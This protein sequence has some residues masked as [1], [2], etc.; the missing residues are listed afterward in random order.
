MV[1]DLSY[2]V[3]YLLQDGSAVRLSAL[4]G[5]L[6]PSDGQH[7]EL[8]HDLVTFIQQFQPVSQSLTHLS[9]GEPCAGCS[10]AA[11]KELL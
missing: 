2:I 8:Q 6:A 7:S 9:C 10:N 11:N 1:L 5:A 3:Q 4:V